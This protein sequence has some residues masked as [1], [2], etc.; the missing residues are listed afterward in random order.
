MAVYAAGFPSSPA[1]GEEYTNSASGITYKWDASSEVWNVVSTPGGGGG[2]GGGGACDVDKAY[3]DRQDAAEASARSQKDDDLQ[4][5]LNSLS[6]GNNPAPDGG[7]SKQELQ[8]ETD[9]R[10]AEDTAI[11][12]EGAAAM[13]NEAKQRLEEDGKLR[14]AI[15]LGSSATSNLEG[16]VDALEASAGAGDGAKDLV[17]AEAAARESADEALN[18]LI[19]AEAT[20]R[21]EADE[22]IKERLAEAEGDIDA[23]EENFEKAITGLGDAGDKLEIELANYATNEKVDSLETTLQEQDKEF[24]AALDGKQPAGD[25]LTEAD[26]ENIDIDGYNDTEVRGLIGDNADAIQHEEKTRE[27]EVQALGALVVLDTAAISELKT[28]GDSYREEYDTRLEEVQ[29]DLEGQIQDVADSVDQLIQD[30]ND[31]DGDLNLDVELAGYAKVDH[32]HDATDITSGTLAHQR[33]PFGS[34]ENQVARGNHTHS[35]QMLRT[36]IQQVASGWAL[37]DGGTA[38]LAEFS[39]AAM[40]AV[41]KAMEEQGVDDP[42][43]L[44]MTKVALPDEVTRSGSTQFIEIKNGQMALTNLKTDSGNNSA[45]T[46]SW[47]KTQLQGKSDVSHDHDSSYATKNHNHDDAYPAKNHNHD[48]TYAKNT[49]D[50]RVTFNV[51][52]NNLFVSWT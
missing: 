8:A 2:G 26:L 51:E 50:K 13:Q 10:I 28:Q 9:A 12:Y 4:R 32:K 3:V 45:A 42:E 17:D 44:D 43:K 38:R 6:G 1:D 21:E 27:A 24:Q 36:G 37:K 52:G 40:A 29:G 41:T 48:S 5:Q 30:I 47:V 46:C 35:W 33:I 14:D 15:D 20:A 7:A 19:E 25:Y 18:V 16:R 39:E 23:L 34:G 49:G 31:H 22:A 11:R